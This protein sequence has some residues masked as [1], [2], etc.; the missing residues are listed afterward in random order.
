MLTGLILKL[1]AGKLPQQGGNNMLLPVVDKLNFKVESAMGSWITDEN[2]KRYLDF[3]TDVGVVSLGYKPVHCSY[4]HMPNHFHLQ[5]REEAAR[6]L[7]DVSGMDYCFFS[8]S[9]AESVEAML[10]LARKYQSQ[11]GRTKI[12]TLKGAFHG[13][14]YGAMSCSYM[15]EGHYHWD[16][17]GP[18]VPDI[19]RFD[20]DDLSTID[21]TAAA[22]LI[23]PG[24]L[25]KDYTPFD[26]HKVWALDNYCKENRILFLMDEV[27][28][29]L[30]LGCWWGKDL[31]IVDPDIICTAKGV[32]GGIATGVTLCKKA[33]G[34]SMKKGGHFSTFG[35]NPLSV[36]GINNVLDIVERDEAFFQKIWAKG[37]LIKSYLKAMGWK[38]VQGDGLLI[39][40]EIDPS[41]N[42]IE[43]RDRCLEK[44]LIIGV[45]SPYG[46]LKLTP[47]LNIAY[48]E[49]DIAMEVLKRCL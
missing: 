18:M 24:F 20:L 37:I 36:R 22:V 44:G 17:Y 35:G 25:N 9:G 28:T 33:I 32:A 46:R 45:F 15:G 1:M 48:E 5:E 41:Y 3:F 13:R 7:C 29:Y 23:T 21:P 27:Q 39:S 14:T 40:A 31:Y 6:R 4:I 34:D 11:F 2:G 43:L 16:G 26:K 10:K 8:N 19:E 49:I 47:P 12:Y 30:R 38:D 42:M